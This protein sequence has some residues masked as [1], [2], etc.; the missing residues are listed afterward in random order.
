MNCFKSNFT[1]TISAVRCWSS[2]GLE[3][4]ADRLLKLLNKGVT[5]G[6]A[7]RVTQTFARLDVLVHAYLMYGVPGEDDQETVDSLERVRQLFQA[8]CLHSAYWHRFAATIHSPIG[9]EPGKYGILPR[10][11]PASTFARNE[12]PFADPAAGRPAELGPGLHLAVYNYMHGIGLD[13]DVR[14]WFDLTP[15]VPKTT[16]PRRFIAQ[17]L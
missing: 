17:F 5:V 11:S 9:R 13:A 8:G 15:A 7:A 14:S 16:V 6:Q 10:P 3:A 12:L 1:R 2:G 4:A